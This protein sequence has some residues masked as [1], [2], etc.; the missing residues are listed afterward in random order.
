M[1]THTETIDVEQAY[2]T[3]FE[4]NT[5]VR[6]TQIMAD[7]YLSETFDANVLL[8]SE[9]NQRTGAYKFRGS[10]NWFSHHESSDL[11]EVIAFSA[12]NHAA[13]VADCAQFF[14]VKAR[15]FMPEDT[16]RFKVDLVR[17]LGGKCVDIVLA[18]QTVDE[19]AEKGRVYL[20]EMDLWDS[21]VHPFDD[22]LVV[23]GQGTIGKELDQRV[24]DLDVVVA[25]VGG[26]GLLSG[27]IHATKH[28]Q[29]LQ[30]V[31][32]E[33]AGAASLD[34]ALKGSESP[35]NTIETFV[36]GA[37]VRQVGG[38]VLRSLEE[39][40]DRYMVVHPDNQTLRRH[41]TRMWQNGE[42]FRPELAGALS[43]A[44]LEKIRPLIKDKTVACIV[45]GGNLSPERFEEEVK[46][47][48]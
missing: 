6:P 11:D 38:I 12:G 44:A 32:A 27:I 42:R 34:H 40:H 1:S 20:D 4:Q 36:D 14:G 46:I 29:T 48:E 3:L 21:F 2:Q 45:S 35:L 41:V 10:F 37:A 7:P 17:K 15:L 39:V 13:A 5:A 47:V 33:P 9:L 8:V 19:A 31:A 18:G 22:P 26:G 43:I 24:S 16:P 30:Y 28:R 25:P 23:S